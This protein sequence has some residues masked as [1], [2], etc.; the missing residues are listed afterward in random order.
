MHSICAWLLAVAIVLAGPLASL[1]EC[2]R[3]PP[4]CPM[5]A[6]RMERE[7]GDGTGAGGHD[8]HAHGGGAAAAQPDATAAQGAV[9]GDHHAAHA[10]PAQ[11]DGT[12]AG[13]TAAGRKKCHD[14]GAPEPAPKPAEGPC[15]SGACGH[16]DVSIA[17][18]L[19]EGVLVRPGARAPE[20]LGAAT[21]PLTTAQPA[22]V[23]LE[24]P[25]E[26]PRTLLA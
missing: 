12:R 7:L 3:C 4:D 17:R 23:A 5:H 13:S 16:M 6:P 8:H 24:P 1:G 9:H 2:L 20:L 26:P 18:A 19:P 11:E 15:I 21:P 22:L 10:A 25:T 14:A